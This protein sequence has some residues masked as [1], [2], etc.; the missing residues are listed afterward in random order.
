MK[1]ILTALAFICLA[2]LYAA[3]KPGENILI[4]ANL[5]IG[6]FVQH[7]NF[8]TAFNASYIKY[9][10][11]APNK[12]TV[13]ISNCPGETSFRQLELQL[14]PGETYKISALVRTH[15]FTSGNYGIAV[16]N[17]GWLNEKG[18]K[19]LPKDMDWTPM[20]STFKLMPSSNGKYS[21]VVFAVASTGTLEVTDMKLEAIS[22]KALA[23]SKRSVMAEYITKPRLIPWKPL[24]NWIPASD[25]AISFRFFGEL[26]IKADGTLPADNDYIIQY[27]AAGKTKSIPFKRGVSRLPLSVP[28]GDSTLKVEILKKDTGTIIF[29]D[30]FTITVVD[31]PT[32]SA[33]NHKRLNNLVTEILNDKLA[34]KNTTQSFIF[35]KLHPGWIFVKAENANAPALEITLDDKDVLI[36][37]QTDRLEAFR[38]IPAG[39]HTITVKGA[40]NGGRIIVRSIVNIFN[41]CPCVNNLLPENPP[42]NWDFLKKYVLPAVTTLNGG[43]IPTAHRQWLRSAGYLWLANLGTTD[44][45]NPEDLL[46][47][48]NKASGLTKPFYDGVTCDEQFFGQDCID[49]YTKGLRLY[50]NQN[51]KLIYTWITGKPSI[52]GMDNEFIATCLNTSRGRARLIHEAYCGTQPTLDAAKKYLQGKLVD[53]IKAYKAYYPDSIRSYGIILGNFNQ[54]PILSLAHHPAVDYKAYLDMQMNII[55]NDPEF[56]GLGVTGYWGSYY[57]DHELHRWAFMLMR[58][59]CVEGNTSMLSDKYGFSYIPGHISNGD[60]IG[61]LDPW[62]PTGNVRTDS[63]PGFASAS[64]NRW[65]AS[66]GDTFAVFTKKADEVSTLSQ[67]A[68]KLIPGKTYCLQFSTVDFNDVKAKRLN[69]RLFGIEASFPSSVV[70]DQKRSWTHIDKRARGRYRHND[71]VARI[72]LHHIVF[73]PKSSTIKL[74]FTNQK[75][76]AGEELGLNYVMLTPFLD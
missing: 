24:L 18:I 60:F 23:M 16:I 46:N 40:T 57:A 75:A 58:H 73:T 53:T 17:R 50:D 21:F 19:D 51:N 26:P 12:R 66:V 76:L 65:G 29:Q 31:I 38:E 14:V 3:V 61:T 7:P 1:R 11:K 48:L 63:C 74:I 33:K 34:P 30:N 47:R 45:K 69:P 67:T 5:D 25:R 41:Y 56:D 37:A 20:S 52:P 13:F 72:N 8:W 64:Q 6:E 28:M 27:T 55:A 68:V 54:I 10:K 15:N 35:S 62:T 4:N 9:G 22:P 32:V 70:I 43:D 44:L 2:Q 59:Y 49:T 36:N 39:K 42:Y 71:N